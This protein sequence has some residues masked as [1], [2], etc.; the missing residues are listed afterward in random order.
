MRFDNVAV[1]SLAH[2][3]ADEVV[4]SASL[5][6][7]LAPLYERFGLSGGRLELMTGI[8]ERRFF[9]RGTRPSDAGT[10]AAELAL[11]R[12]PIA[13]ERIELLIHAAVCRDFIEPATASLVHAKLGLTERAWAFDLSNA[14][15]GFANAITVAAG[16]IARGDIA[17]ALI[18]SAEDGRAL[19]ESTLTGLLTR[20]DVDRRMLKT[21]FASLTIGSGAAAMILTHASLAPD[22]PRLV[23]TLA[24]AASQHHGL[25]H[26]DHVDALGGPW[27]E[28]DS[29]ALL[30]AGNALAERTFGPFLDEAGWTR[31]SIDRVV[32]HQVGV[33]H[34]RALFETLGLDRSR[35]FPT[36]ETLGNMGSASLPLS[37]SLAAETG[38]I[39]PGDRVAGLGIGSGLQ[40]QM[41]A[42][43]W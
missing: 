31:A 8:R 36:V 34:R 13:R 28:T 11:A 25:C 6:E 16:Q 17:A 4:S 30:V 33:A 1:A 38:A 12:A 15:L 40:C 14:C 19:V 26:G 7:R 27:M 2:V 35:D 32:T 42:L 41:L 43:R 18:V 5:E 39:R 21:A 22:A 10:R 23:A 37:L 9:A 24:R 3:L 20:T 29:E